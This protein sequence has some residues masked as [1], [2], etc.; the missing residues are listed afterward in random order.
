MT[1]RH[2]HY[3]IRL[4]AWYLNSS[5]CNLMGTDWNYIAL[6][7][8]RNMP[9]KQRTLAPFFTFVLVSRFIDI[10][11]NGKTL[12][13]LYLSTWFPFWLWVLFPWPSSFSFLQLWENCKT[14][15]QTNI[16]LIGKQNKVRTTTKKSTL[17]HW[18]IQQ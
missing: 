17:D 3:T 9:G 1:L 4:H 6:S 5:I 2:V 8:L 7:C 14:N 12:K 15:K 18:C 11:L 16:F 10:F 13:G